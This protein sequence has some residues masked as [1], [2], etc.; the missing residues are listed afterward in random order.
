MGQTST[1]T[2]ASTSQKESIDP[3]DAQAYY[4]RAFEYHQKQEY[5]RALAD[6]NQVIE[7]DSDRSNEK[8]YVNRGLIYYNL[9]KDEDAIAD[10]N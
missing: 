6:Y 4:D 3:N 9:G 1:Q 5:D 10:Y 2:A 8:A 7:L